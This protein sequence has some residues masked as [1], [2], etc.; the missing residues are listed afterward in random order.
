VAVQNEGQRRRLD[1]RGLLEPHL[2]R[3]RLK[4]R[5]RAAITHSVNRHAAAHHYF[6]AY[7]RNEG[8]A[9]VIPTKVVRGQTYMF[10]N[11]LFRLCCIVTDVFKLYLQI[12]V[13]FLIESCVT[14]RDSY[15]RK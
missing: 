10:I 15:F 7:I 5:A 9:K 1:L 8:S 14:L 6:N 12:D 3:E 2:E 4:D 13:T 11:Y